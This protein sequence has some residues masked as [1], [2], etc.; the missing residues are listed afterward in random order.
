MRVIVVAGT[1]SG[2]GKTTIASA[3]MLAYAR[4]G[5]RVRAFKV[6]ADFVDPMVHRVALRQS[7]GESE[8]LDGYMMSAEYNAQ[9]VA[10]VCR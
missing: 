9:S 10:K 4:R 3:L 6:G 1:H 7:A 2:V 8:N 5:L